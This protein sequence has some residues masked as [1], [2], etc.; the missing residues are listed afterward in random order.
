MDTIL[1]DTVTALLESNHIPFQK[2]ELRKELISHPDYPALNAVTDSLAWMG[3]E[4]VAGQLSPAGLIENGAPALVYLPRQ[5]NPVV[6]LEKA[7]NRRIVIYDFH[8]RKR[9]VYTPE[10]FANVWSGVA[11]Y[12][13]SGASEKS[14]TVF[15]RKYRAVGIGMAVILMLVAGVVLGFRMGK[16]L[17]VVYY[18]WT[19]LKGL[20]LCICVAL[21]RHELDLSG[22]ILDKLCSL[23]P[24]FSC[25][26][27]LRSG[28]SRLFGTVRLADLGTVYFAGGVLL[29]MQAAWSPYLQ[30]FV[31]VLA[32]LALLSVGYV[33]FSL[34]YQR[35]VVKKWCP[36]CLAVLLVL[37]SEAGLAYC[38]FSR[39]TYS[40]PALP[41]VL[42][43]GWVFLFLAAV[44]SVLYRLT[45]KYVRLERKETDYFRLLKNRRIGETC[46]E[47][48]PE[49]DTESLPLK[50]GMAASGAAASITAVLSLFCTSCGNVCRTLL[51]LSRRQATVHFCLIP[52]VDDETAPSFR[53]TGYF[54]GIFLE[55]GESVFR[56]ALNSWLYRTDFEALRRWFPIS[57]NAFADGIEQAKRQKAWIVARH[58]RTTPAIWIGR[59]KL[60]AWLRPDDL[61]HFLQGVVS[62]S[63]YDEKHQ[64][65]T[66]R[67]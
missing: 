34:L 59:K 51:T 24:S 27:V 38:L 2:K 36:L 8:A 48:A 57:G 20:G 21:I 46:L 10:T 12:T 41:A 11:L 45:E 56:E 67:T 17:P 29:L 18:L 63:G 28:A 43:I 42:W 14:I 26:A 40:R 4:A 25:S 55:K 31:P 23:A 3:I 9:T 61:P 62:A 64:S 22:G 52:P 54:Y 65:Q 13:E 49:L 33:L 47:E 39:F 32:G 50:T 15:L 66:S 19:A 7:D 53:T 58:I 16:P 60:P 35:F 1:C 30:S 44:W 37:L 6:L 5:D